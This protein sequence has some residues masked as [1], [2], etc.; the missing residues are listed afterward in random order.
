MTEI[1][2][3][4]K[5][6]EFTVAVSPLKYSVDVDFCV[7]ISDKIILKLTFPNLAAASVKQ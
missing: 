6:R 1:H 3:C 4:G 5:L 2:Y 7:H